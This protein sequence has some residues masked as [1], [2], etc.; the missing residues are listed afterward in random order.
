[1]N[2]EHRPTLARADLDERLAGFRRSLID[3][4][5]GVAVI[6][7]VVA[8]INNSIA[9]AQGGANPMFATA[10]ATSVLVILG[11]FVLDKIPFGV[12][13]VVALALQLA[14][15]FVNFFAGGM[16][17]AGWFWFV[18]AAF[19]AA[20]FYS[21]RVGQIGL[22]LFALLVIY[23]GAG[24]VDATIVASFDLDQR[25]R[26]VGAW[27]RFFSVVVMLSMIVLYM[28]G[29]Y[30]EA[31]REL[32]KEIDLQRDKAETASHAKSEFL[33]NMSRELKT[34][35][36]A[37]LKHAQAIEN[38]IAATT[39]Q[40]EHSHEIRY[41]G[42]LLLHL[43]DDL[44][45]LPRVE[46]GKIELAIQ[47]TTPGP[48]MRRSI[49]LLSESARKAQVTLIDESG[50][51]VDATI[52]VDPI[53]LLQVLSNFLSNAIKYN[54]PNGQVRVSCALS[55]DTLRIS[56]RDTGV[57]IPEDKWLRVFDAFDR[58]GFEGSTIEGAGIGLMISKNIVKAMGG[59]IG[60]DSI[61]RQ[62]SVFWVEFPVVTSSSADH[63]PPRPAA[64]TWIDRAH[65]L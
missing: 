62:G 27:V 31:I 35:L 2:N 52:A 49:E 64:A 58:L 3:R 26:D 48:L 59:A 37:M 53:R 25:N 17:G 29:G 23:V 43:I 38:D 11:Y 60:F 57:G 40:K 44:L 13:V 16:F 56:V 45:D 14:M 5:W 22:L 39:A 55:G 19:L 42:K 8:V 34:P 46:A 65:S 21:I 6:L 51:G 10:I 12:K 36:E 54:L 18:S 4:T 33:A 20:V 30:L 41:A 24:Y 63:A 61:E 1:M 7:A 28:I 9:I 47:P 32:L 50:T 15:G